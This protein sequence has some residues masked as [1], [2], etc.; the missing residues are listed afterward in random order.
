V[1]VRWC[2]GFDGMRTDS[3]RRNGSVRSVEQSSS[4]R[5]IQ[6]LPPGAHVFYCGAAVF[7]VSAFRMCASTDLIDDGLA[8]MRLSALSMTIWWYGHSSRPSTKHVT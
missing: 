4:R 8:D 2:S 3:V 6:Q 7:V 5:D 1:H